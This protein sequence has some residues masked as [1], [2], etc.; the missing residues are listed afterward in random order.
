MDYQRTIIKKC[1]KWPIILRLIIIAFWKLVLLNPLP[2]HSPEGEKER[3]LPFLISKSY[4]FL[5]IFFVCLFH[6]SWSATFFSPHLLRAGTV[7]GEHTYAYM[8]AYTHTHT[9][10]SF[11]F[12]NLTGLNTKLLNWDN[13]NIVLKLFSALKQNLLPFLKFI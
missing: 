7:G 3:Q 8:A 5:M 1:G 2:R 6:W 13:P 10:Y 4:E 11:G 9:H 12:F